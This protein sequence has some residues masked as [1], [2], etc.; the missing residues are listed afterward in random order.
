MKIEEGGIIPKIGAEDLTI[1]SISPVYFTQKQAEN[2]IKETKVPKGEEAKTPT[3]ESFT[4]QEKA[5]ELLAAVGGL[6]NLFTFLNYDYRFKVHEATEEV[7]LLVIDLTKHPEKVIKE[8]PA[9]KF[10]DL[11]AQI[12]QAVGMI[13]D[14]YV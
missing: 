12:Q 8:I 5:K 7:M 2:R 10:L 14:E 3:E 4:F 6:N 1:K 11:L 9:E 13:I